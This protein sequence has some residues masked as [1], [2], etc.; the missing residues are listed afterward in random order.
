M[1]GPE[2]LSAI[3]AKVRKAFQASDADLLAW[4]NRQPEDVAQEPKANKAALEGLRLLRDALLSETKRARPRRGGRRNAGRA[5][6]GSS[7]G[8]KRCRFIFYKKGELTPFSMLGVSIHRECKGVVTDVQA[9][10]RTLQSSAAAQ[11]TKSRG[12]ARRAGDKFW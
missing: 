4:F 2:K 7:N 3:R 1:M 11:A 9:A 12:V 5:Q 8:T 6:T 10:L